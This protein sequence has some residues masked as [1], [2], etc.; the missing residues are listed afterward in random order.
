MKGNLRIL[1]EGC[2]ALLPLGRQLLAPFVGRGDGGV[3][4][5]ILHPPTRVTRARD[6]LRAQAQTAPDAESTLGI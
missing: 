2:L 4:S 3:A 6:N 1:L 5:E